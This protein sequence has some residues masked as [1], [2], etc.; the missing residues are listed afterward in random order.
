MTINMINNNNVTVH[1]HMDRSITLHP[2]T[3]KVKK[4]CVSAVY[5]GP[6]VKH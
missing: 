3:V 5:G 1:I 4:V 6:R 2:E